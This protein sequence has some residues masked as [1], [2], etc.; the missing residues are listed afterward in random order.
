MTREGLASPSA[1]PGRSLP[2]SAGGEVVD[3]DTRDG[4]QRA[5]TIGWE[6]ARK[7]YITLGESAPHQ[8]ISGRRLPQI[9]VSGSTLRVTLVGGAVTGYPTNAPQY[10]PMRNRSV[11]PM[12][13][14]ISVKV[15]L[16]PTGRPARPA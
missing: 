9:V 1:A 10:Y 7:T 15:Q 5:P 14:V 3:V 12:A 2:A 8:L 11:N 4:N 16:T 13:Q 6:T